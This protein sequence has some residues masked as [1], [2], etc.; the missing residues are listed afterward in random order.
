MYSR[1]VQAEGGVLTIWKERGRKRCLLVFPSA[2]L[3]SETSLRL[4]LVMDACATAI[5]DQGRIRLEEAVTLTYAQAGP[6]S[7]TAFDFTV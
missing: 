1:E 2:I 5:H 7:P 4:T 3:E 6:S